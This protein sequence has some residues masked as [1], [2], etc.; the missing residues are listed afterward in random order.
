M[1]TKCKTTFGF[2]FFLCILRI[3]FCFLS[4]LTLTGFYLLLSFWD[5]V[6][7]LSVTVKGDHWTYTHNVVVLSASE[8]DT[9]VLGFFESLII[10]EIFWPGTG[11][12]I[13]G[14]IAVAA[15]VNAI[16]CLIWTMKSKYSDQR[17]S[18]V[19]MNVWGTSLKKVATWVNAGIY[20]R[21]PSW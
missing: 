5:P 21:G 1:R 11:I 15:R 8:P 17:R 12:A 20:S 3:P 18:Y 7:W 14:A 6:L 4:F 9:A 16:Q 2:K 10:A 19:V 13:A